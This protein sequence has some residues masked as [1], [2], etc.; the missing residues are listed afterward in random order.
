MKPAPCNETPRQ[1]RPLFAI[2][3]IAA[4]V[5]GPIVRSE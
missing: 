3:G 5:L 2:S 4:L 1:L